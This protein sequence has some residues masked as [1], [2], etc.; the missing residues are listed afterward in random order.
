M[1]S[2]NQIADE[3]GVGVAD[4]VTRSTQLDSTSSH[5]PHCEPQSVAEGICK[6]SP[7]AFIAAAAFT[8]GKAGMLFKSGH[9]GLGYYADASPAEAESKC[10]ATSLAGK[11]LPVDPH[12][13]ALSMSTDM[14]STASCT[15][16]VPGELSSKAPHA[17]G[18]MPKG[19]GKAIQSGQKEDRAMGDGLE[20][21]CKAEADGQMKGDMG[22]KTGHYW[23]QA[24]QYLDRS[25]QVWFHSGADAYHPCLQPSLMNPTKPR[26]VIILHG[27]NMS[28]PCVA[29][30]AGSRKQLPWRLQCHV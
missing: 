7:A 3:E 26:V 18:C 16:S 6:G 1:N 13:T 24:L 10:R 22:V 11:E 25:V 14:C 9:Q 29:Q 20:G 27:S 4:A 5:V 12:T 30:G 17:K 21:R 23:G 19:N 8:G 15:D 2:L 28:Q